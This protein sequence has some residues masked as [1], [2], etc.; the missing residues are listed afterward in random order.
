MLLLKEFEMFTRFTRY[1]IAQYGIPFP[2]KGHGTKDTL[3]SG[4]TWDR[5]TLP[6]R[7]DWQKPV[8]TL[9]SHNYCWGRWKG[10]RS[11]WLHREC[12]GLFILG[13]D[14]DQRKNYFCFRSNTK[15][16]LVAITQL[17]TIDVFLWQ[18]KRNIHVK[19]I[20]RRHSTF[21][22]TFKR[23]QKRILPA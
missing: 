5:D 15:E 2:Q 8:K 10:R 14:K 16:A 6:P 17:A 4:G 22:L 12:Y 9:P 11:R 1:G 3:T 18:Q 20:F 13:S 21:S 7:T 23:W 19:N